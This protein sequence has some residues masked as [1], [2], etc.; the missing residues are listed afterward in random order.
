MYKY[1]MSGREE[2]GETLL[3]DVNGTRDNGHSF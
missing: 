3:S 1:L 2:E